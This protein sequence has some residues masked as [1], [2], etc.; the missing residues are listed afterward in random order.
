MHFKIRKE[1]V[2][3]KRQELFTLPEH[4][5][6]PPLLGANRVAHRFSFLCCVVL[7]LN[8]INPVSVKRVTRDIGIAT[9][10]VNKTYNH[11]TTPISG[12][13]FGRHLQLITTQKL[14]RKTGHTRHN[15]K[16]KYKKQTHN[17][18]QKTCCIY[19]F[20]Y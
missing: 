19:L 13:I 9:S 12:I 11:V 16:T 8:T 20:F 3:Y 6:S 10:T 14:K 7:A 15:T 5:G 18:T 4:L 2:Y 17:T 1:L